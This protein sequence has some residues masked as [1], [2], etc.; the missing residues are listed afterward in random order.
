MNLFYQP[1]ITENVNHLDEEESRHCSKV[2]RK[3]SGDQIY[4]TDGKGCLYNARIINADSRKCTF[5][6]MDKQEEKA[7]TFSI[8]IA[9]APTKN[10]D[11]ME[12]FVEKSVEFGIDHITLME[13]DNSERNFL[14]LDRLRKVA[15]S[16]MKQS[17]KRTLPVVDGIKPFKSVVDAVNPTDQ[18]FVAF[19]D[20]DN[21]LHLKDAATKNGNY[22]VLIGPEGDFSE[23]ELN[24][25]I[26]R[27][28]QKVS[29]GSSR[30]RTET[31]GIAACHILNLINS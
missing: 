6:V 7:R 21:Q 24:L 14:K 4:I 11:R 15:I 3:K 23:V 28:F 18:K 19:V 29:L 20:P 9:I 2:L 27:E 5:E 25:A 31:A 1:L 17:F 12:W 22:F 10:P 30:L 13:C 26:Q 16:A 8:H